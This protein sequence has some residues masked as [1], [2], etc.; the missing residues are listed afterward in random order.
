MNWLIENDKLV[1]Q[2][3]FKNQ[4]KLAEFF[5]IIAIHADE[6]NHHPDVSIFKASKM[7]IELSTHDKDSITELDYSLAKFI[8]EAFEKFNA[9]KIE[10]L[11]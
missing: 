9:E 8:D 3:S 2:F 5:G 10:I 11:S 6:V 7:K 1:K 4:R